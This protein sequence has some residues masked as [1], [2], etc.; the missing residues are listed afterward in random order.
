MAYVIRVGQLL[1]EVVVSGEKPA[2]LEPLREGRV[3]PSERWGER[4][5]IIRC[6]P[7]TILCSDGIIQYE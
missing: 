1:A 2:A 5:T 3:L 4:G 7:L 6:F